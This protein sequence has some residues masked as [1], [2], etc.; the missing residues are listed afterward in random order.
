MNRAR[1]V[2]E[3]FLQRGVNT[4]DILMQ[5]AEEEDAPEAAAYTGQTGGVLEMVKGLGQKFEEEQADLEKAEMNENH[6]FNMM[7]Q[8]LTNSI[9][10][11]ER[12]R[13][14]KAAQKAE[15]QK[16]KSEAEGDETETGNGLQADEKFLSDLTAECEQKAIEFEQNQQT[17]AGEIEAIN[18]AIEIISSDKVQGKDSLVQQSS[19]PQVGDENLALLQ[20]RT[21]ARA[22][23]QDDVS[24]FLAERARA[25]DSSIL[26]LLSQR[27]ASDPFKKVTKMIKDM[28]VKLMEEANEEADHKGFCDT[29]LGQNKITRDSKTEESETLKAQIE[30]LSADAGKLGAEIADLASEVAAIDSAMSKATAVR[31]AEKEKNEATIADAKTAQEA[32]SQALSVLKDFYEKA[33][34]NAAFAQETGAGGPIDYDKRAM[35]II[36]G[37]EASFV[38]EAEPY[39]GQEGGGVLGMLEVIASDFARLESET[40]AAEDESAKGFQEFSTDSATNKAVKGQEMKDK[41]NE[42]QKKESE[43]ASAKKDLQGTMEELDAALVYF[44]K[45]K[46]SC[47]DAGE[48]YEERVARRKE[49]IESLQEALK[50]LNGED[51]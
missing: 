32:V 40:A 37:G 11:A 27:V 21:S 29:E 7:Q 1:R 43:M 5:D 44:D 10:G 34:K 14:K 16:L 26:S 42:K 47:V 46:P 8:D 23:A 13:G 51:I 33:A 49:E 22:Q 3:S 9:E 35:A 4:H 31:M 41:G 20:I 17:R 2:V 50:I 6:A 12:M 28:I 24:R 30:G 45:L 18:K 36:N 39:K 38:Q 15:K 19:D 48:T 25:T